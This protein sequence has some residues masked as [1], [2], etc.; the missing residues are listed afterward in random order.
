MNDDDKSM[1]L[2]EE[3]EAEA[4]PLRLLEDILYNRMMQKKQERCY[5]NY[6]QI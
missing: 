2:P 1:L 3:P 5:Y 4:S 6:K